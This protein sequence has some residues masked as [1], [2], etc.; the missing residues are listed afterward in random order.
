MVE[1]DAVTIAGDFNTPYVSIGRA[2]SP[3][4]FP[5][6]KTSIL[7][8]ITY[9]SDNNDINAW[10]LSGGKDYLNRR[11][12]EISYGDIREKVN[13]QDASVKYYT[14][15][16][17]GLVSG[18]Y[19]FELLDFDKIEKQ[20]RLLVVEDNEKPEVYEEVDLIGF[21][22]EN[23]NETEVIFRHR[24][25]YEP[26]KTDILNFWLRED[27]HMTNHYDTDFLLSNTRMGIEYNQFGVIPNIFFSKVSPSSIMKISKNSSGKS[28]F[29][30]R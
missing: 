28:L 25:R 3:L 29:S 30:R 7:P 8:S 26:K 6:V 10:Y 20:N 22:I 21:D 4:S 13:A 11:L 14:V 9:T 16:D 12:E 17:T 23:V 2:N 1:S 27:E 24:G 5:M 15:T 19:R 18:D